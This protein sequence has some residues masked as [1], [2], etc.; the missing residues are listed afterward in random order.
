M[1]RSIELYPVMGD[2]PSRCATV[3][4]YVFK[5]FRQCEKKKYMTHN[6]TRVMQN[7]SDFV[8]N[9]CGF[10]PRNRSQEYIINQ[11]FVCVV[12]GLLFIPTV[13]LNG[14]SIFTILK[15]SQLNEK[16]S[17]FSI[18]IQSAVDLVTGMIAIPLLMAF[19]LF[20]DIIQIEI[21]SVLINFMCIKF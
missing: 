15:C 7:L 16:V 9:I 3:Y 5:F 17:Y 2:L 21:W 8:S 18:L 1:L 10:F 6:N 19:V 12:Y 13:L 20:R 4:I 11:I 14:V